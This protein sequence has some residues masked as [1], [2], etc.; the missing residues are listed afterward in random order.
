MYN[1]I[2]L[3]ESQQAKKKEQEEERVLIQTIRETIRKEKSKKY[4]W[5]WI[6]GLLIGGAMGLLI[7]IFI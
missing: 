1:R 2:T 7:S 3:Y 6:I 4:G 5:G